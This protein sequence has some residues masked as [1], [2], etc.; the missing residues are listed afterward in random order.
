M[1]MWLMLTSG[2]EGMPLPYSPRTDDVVALILL[3]CF[4]LSSFALARSKKFLSQQAKDLYCIGN[5]PVSLLFL[6]Q[7]MFG[8][9][10]C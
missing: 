7:Q 6:R 3:T 9:C 5:V 8:I 10:C 1:S 2:F 4:F